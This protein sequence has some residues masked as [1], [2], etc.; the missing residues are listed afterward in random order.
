M[1]ARWTRV[2]V[3]FGRIPG[4]HIHDSAHLAKL[5]SELALGIKSEMTRTAPRIDGR[6]RRARR[7]KLSRLGIEIKDEHLVDAQVGDDGI[8]IVG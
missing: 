3:P 6:E 5:V 7:R 4:K 8:T 2:S 1:W